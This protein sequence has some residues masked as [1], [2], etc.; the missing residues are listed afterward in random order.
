MPIPDPAT[1]TIAVATV[2][3]WL[4]GI[5]FYLGRYSARQEALEHKADGMAATIVQIFQKLDKLAEVVPHKC[6]QVATIAAMQRDIAIGGQRTAELET[7]RH[8]FEK[9]PT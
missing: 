6:D 1:V 9:N 4:L 2:L 5:S 8:S 7:W 3:T